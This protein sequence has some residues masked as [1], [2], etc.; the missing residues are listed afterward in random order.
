MISS[1]EVKAQDNF[2]FQSTVHGRC[3]AEF[4]TLKSYIRFVKPEGGLKLVVSYE[5]P[6]HWKVINGLVQS[7]KDGKSAEELKIIRAD[8]VNKMTASSP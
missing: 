7:V 1:S 8:I 4:Y 3:K 2:W 6:R 5:G